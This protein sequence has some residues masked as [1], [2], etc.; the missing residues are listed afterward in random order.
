MTTCRMTGSNELEIEH[1]KKLKIDK[2]LSVAICK[3]AILESFRVETL[4][5]SRNG[6]SG[7]ED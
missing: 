4:D 6:R 3:S 5:L 2:T 1:N 7:T